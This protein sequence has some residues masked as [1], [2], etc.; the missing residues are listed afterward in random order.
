MDGNNAKKEAVSRT[1]LLPMN[2]IINMEKMTAQS[3]FYCSRCHSILSIMEAQ[4]AT[5]YRCI[6][7]NREENEITLFWH[8]K[9]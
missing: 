6:I 8:T 9:N 7:N 1:K 2:T 4:D 5:C 3:M